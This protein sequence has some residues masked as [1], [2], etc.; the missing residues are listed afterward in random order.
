MEAAVRVSPASGP[1]EDRALA[2]PTGGGY[3]VAVADVQAAPAMEQPLL[4]V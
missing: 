1:G 2:V 3:L 4:N